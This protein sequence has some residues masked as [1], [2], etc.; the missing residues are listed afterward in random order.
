MNECD[1]NLLKFVKLFKSI[2]F[3]KNI[4]F[5]TSFSLLEEFSKK[6]QFINMKIRS[7]FFKINVDN[8]LLRSHNNLIN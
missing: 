7:L 3:N 6:I 4:E 2:N 5:F 8:F 1:K